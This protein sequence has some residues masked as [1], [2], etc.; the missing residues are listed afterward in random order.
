MPDRFN[1][2]IP[3]EPFLY[4][5]SRDVVED[6]TIELMAHRIVAWGYL[7]YDKAE[8]DTL[9]PLD[10]IP[11]MI[12][13]EYYYGY[14]PRLNLSQDI[15]SDRIRFL[16]IM[17]LP[18]QCVFLSQ[19]ISPDFLRER[20]IVDIN[21]EV[22]ILELFHLAPYIAPKDSLDKVWTPWVPLPS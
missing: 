10:V 4:Y 21:T 16:R 20:G 9:G 5:I 22:N 8:R 17:F 15:L 14:T 11:L 12:P 13:D 18:T 6:R 2:I 7:H 1:H 19:I 3:A